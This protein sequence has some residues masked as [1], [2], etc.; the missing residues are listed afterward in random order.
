[1]IGILSYGA[2]VPPTRQ[3]LSTI[4]GGSAEPEDPVPNIEGKLA[5]SHNIGGHPTACGIALLGRP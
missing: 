2:Y 3:P 5:L 1:M 4:G